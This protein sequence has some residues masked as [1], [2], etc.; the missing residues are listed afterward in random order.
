MAQSSYVAFL[1]GINVGGKGIL[2]MSDL[3]AALATPTFANVRTYIQSG[4]V[5]FTSRE[6]DTVLLGEKLR[7]RVLARHQIDAGVAVFSLDQWRAVLEQAPEWWNAEQTWKHN[8]L[9]LIPPFDQDAVVAAIGELKPGIERLQA[10]PGVLYQSIALD[11]FSRSSGAKISRLA[12]YRQM[13]IRNSNTARK[14]LPLLED[15]DSV[16]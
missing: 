14:L 7:S 10:G 2:R 16:A 8:L 6:T 5:L 12:V 15:L 3:V 13:T 9:I 1:R 4:N 11:G